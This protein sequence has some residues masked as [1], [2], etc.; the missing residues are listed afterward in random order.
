MLQAC[1]L[2][3]CKVEESPVRLEK[4]MNCYNTAFDDL[5]QHDPIRDALT[6]SQTLQKKSTN[7]VENEYDEDQVFPSLLWW[8][9]E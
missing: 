3:A 5:P 8:V 7:S 1:I 9:N 4:I 2:L 6:I